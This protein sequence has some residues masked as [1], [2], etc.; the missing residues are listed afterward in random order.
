MRVKFF[1]AF[2]G[3]ETGEVFY[4]AGQVVEL[5]DNQAERLLKDGRCGIV[6]ALQAEI[7]QPEPTPEPAPEAIE[8]QPAPVKRQRRKAS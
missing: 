3:V 8:E 5:P 7:P 2:Q 4:E 1:Q 6:P